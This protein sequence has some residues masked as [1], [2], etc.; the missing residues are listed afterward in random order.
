MGTGALEA[1]A[2]DNKGEGYDNWGLEIRVSSSVEFSC[3]SSNG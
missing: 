1:F 3:E 2:L